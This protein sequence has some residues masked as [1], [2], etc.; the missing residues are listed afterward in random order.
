MVS[1]REPYCQNASKSPA[2]QFVGAACDPATDQALL[3]SGWVGQVQQSMHSGAV[4]HQGAGQECVAKVL[5]A[6]IHANMPRDVYCKCPRVNE[7]LEI[8][9]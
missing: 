6:C 1:G 2:V 4:N 3:V 8:L 7:Y 9:L 5:G